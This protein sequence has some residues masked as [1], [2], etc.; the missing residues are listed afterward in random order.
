MKSILHY[1]SVLTLILLTFSCKKDNSIDIE[2]PLEGLTL[3]QTIKNNQHQIEL[4]TASGIIEQGYNKIYVRIKNQDAT[5]VKNAEVNWQP[6][7]HMTSMNHSCPN[8]QPV[9]ANIDV[10]LYQ[11]VLIFQMASNDTEYWDLTFN[12]TINN[13]SYTATDK[14]S[15]KASAKQRVITFKGSDNVKYILALVNPKQP[16][17]GINDV[18]AFLYKMDNMTTFTPINNY[19]IKMDPRMPGMGNHGSPNN[20]D[21]IKSSTIGTYKGKLSLTMTGY[22]KINLQLINSLNE[23]IKGEIV[24]GGVE[25]SSVYWEIEF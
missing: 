18:D 21:L 7:M 3:V 23:V 8:I 19:I 12:Y 25:S 11:G 10:G 14:L 20:V 17:V 15:V 13:Q 24:T 1:I 4:F 22:W 9:L 2:N 16:K 5:L 6:M